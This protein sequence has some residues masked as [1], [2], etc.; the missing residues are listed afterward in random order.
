[1]SSPSKGVTISSK[2]EAAMGIQYRIDENVKQVRKEV[3]QEE[4]NLSSAFRCKLAIGCV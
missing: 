2:G 4:R 1:M 3:P